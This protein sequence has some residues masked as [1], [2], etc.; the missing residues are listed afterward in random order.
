MSKVDLHVH[1]TASDGKLSSEEVVG[2]SA[3]QD[4]VIIALTD[5]DTVDGIAP[6]L[7]AAKAFPSLQVIPGVELST[8]AP[9]SEVHV[10]GYFIDYTAPELRV[11]LERMRNSRQERAQEMIN[12][13]RGLGIHIEWP[14][15]K[16]IAG[17]GSVGRPHLAQ[18]M[19]EKGYIASFKEAFNNFIGRGGPAYVRRIKMTPVEAIEL[20]LGTKGLPVLAHPLTVDDSEVMVSELKAVGLVGIEAYYDGYTAEEIAG[21]VSL[22][23]RYNLVATGGSDYHGIDDTETVIGGVEVP[24]EAAERLIALVEPRALKLTDRSTAEPAF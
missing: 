14:R 22:A 7:E 18:A 10:L 21:L 2:R 16:E 11:R 24:L 20:I 13:L 4:L 1:S 8:D 15:V 19:L 3:G 23:D 6:A 5:H 9:Q 12:K 17:S